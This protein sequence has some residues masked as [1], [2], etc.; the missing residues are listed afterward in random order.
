MLCIMPASCL[1]ENV[2]LNDRLNGFFTAI[3]NV[4]TMRGAVQFPTLQVSV[5]VQ[6]PT[7]CCVR[8]R[9]FPPYVGCGSVAVCQ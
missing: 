2:A 1:Q 9:S 3:N 5:A 6:Y 8:Q 7:P 4:G